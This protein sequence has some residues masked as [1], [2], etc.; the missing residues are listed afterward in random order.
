MTPLHLRIALHY[1]HYFVSPTVSYGAGDSDAHA[2]SP[3]VRNYK[4]E[5]VDAG[6]LEFCDDGIRVK[7]TEALS[8]YI[9]ALCSV[10]L[11]VQKWVIPES[12]K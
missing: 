12:E 9:E 1:F 5:L 8:V 7:T 11:P 10:P 3:A 6:L 2:I 4:K